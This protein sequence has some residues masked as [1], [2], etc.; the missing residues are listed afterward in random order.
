MKKHILL[1]FLLIILAGTTSAQKFMHGVGTG[2]FINSGTG[3]HNSVPTILTYSPRINM[4]DRENFSVSVGLPFSVGFGSDYNLYS[5][6]G[7]TEIN[8]ATTFAINVPLICNVNL[9]AGASKSSTKRTGFFAG[10]GFAYQYGSYVSRLYNNTTSEYV[11]FNADAWGPAANIGI[12]FAV[13]R[14]QKNI[15]ARVSYMGSVTEHKIS[16]I[17]I[18]ALFNF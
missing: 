8:S 2:V 18:A 10:A 7:S 3:I 15:E 12:R 14:K 5:Q 11:K 16:A 9:G 1:S 13:G 4:V 6:N 17:G